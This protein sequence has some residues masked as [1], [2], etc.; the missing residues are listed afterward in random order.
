MPLLRAG[1]ALRSRSSAEFYCLTVKRRE[2]AERTRRH[3]PG[4]Q[5]N[6]RQRAE[7]KGVLGGKGSWVTCSKCGIMKRYQPRPSGKGGKGGKG[8]KSL[9]CP[10]CTSEYMAAYRADARRREREQQGSPDVIQKKS[11]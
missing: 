4:R 7:I 5:R 10:S 1:K 8:W 3:V 9:M 11:H 2:W 6:Y